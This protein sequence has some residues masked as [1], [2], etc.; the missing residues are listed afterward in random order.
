MRYLTLCMGF[1]FPIAFL[2][3]PLIIF[4]GLAASLVGQ[5][6]SFALPA[7]MELHC[8]YSPLKVTD[9]NE[10]FASEPGVRVT[11]FRAIRQ[12]IEQINCIRA[13][14]DATMNVNLLHGPP[15]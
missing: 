11:F 15:L 2:M 13:P 8:F 4:Q 9:Y 1:P 14:A 6:G 5:P 7:V 12:S 3:G 10:H